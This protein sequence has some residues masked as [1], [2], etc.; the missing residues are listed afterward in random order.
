MNFAAKCCILSMN[1]DHVL[2]SLPHIR[3]RYIRNVAL[4]LAH[5]AVLGLQSSHKF[6]RLS[7]IHRTYTRA[8]NHPQPVSRSGENEESV[9]KPLLDRRFSYEHVFCLFTPPSRLPFVAEDHQGA[10]HYK[11]YYAKPDSQPC[12]LRGP[13][14][15]QA[16]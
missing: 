14:V 2:A 7:N 6:Y 1:A 13:P 12:N 4:V 8:S 10:L 16:I 15:G 11:S 5:L 9:R 3:F